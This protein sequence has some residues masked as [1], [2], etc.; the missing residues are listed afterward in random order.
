MGLLMGLQDGVWQLAGFVFST[1]LVGIS[2]VQGYIYFARNKHG[3]WAS[4]SLV[5][6]LLILDPATSLLFAHTIYYYFLINFGNYRVFSKVTSSWC[7]ENAITSII[8]WIVQL[9]FALRIYQLD[10]QHPLLPRPILNWMIPA[11]VVFLAFVSFALGIARTAFMVFQTTNHL[12]TLSVTLVVDMEE[13]CAVICDIITTSALCYMLSPIRSSTRKRSPV[14]TVFIFLI[15]RGILVNVVQLGT[16]VTYSY[17]PNKLYWMSFHLC[18]SKVYINT[19][20]AMVNSP[21]N[22]PSSANTRPSS[23]LEFRRSIV[24]MPAISSNANHDT[25]S[26]S[27]SDMTNNYYE[28]DMAA[29]EA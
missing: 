14:R 1:A 27:T 29:P 25:P 8:V 15:D 7:A 5:I 16:L 28:T 10:K 23:K 13:G 19:F 6:L 9:Y 2:V 11:F 22:Q 17:A 24:V 26:V 3:H 20:F 4:K 12:A 18:K 21:E